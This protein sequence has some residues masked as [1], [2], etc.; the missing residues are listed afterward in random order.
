MSDEIGEWDVDVNEDDDGVV[1]DFTHFAETGVERFSTALPREQA[2]S[3]ATAIL[4]AAVQL[5]DETEQ[6]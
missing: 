4:N 2:L 5:P 3:L 1:L 6:R